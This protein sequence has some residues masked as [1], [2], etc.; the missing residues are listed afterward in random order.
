MSHP[1][2]KPLEDDLFSPQA[3]D[4]VLDRLAKATDVLDLLR[5]ADQVSP[6][7][8][9]LWSALILGS[10]EDGSARLYLHSSAPITPALALAVSESMHDELAS[11]CG[12]LP[13]LGG[14]RQAGMSCGDL[15]AEVINRF[16][17]AFHDQVTQRGS[18]PIGITRAGAS[19]ADG[20]TLQRWREA[21]SALEVAA[22]LVGTLTDEGLEDDAG[23]RDPITGQYSRAFFQHTLKNELA[24]HQRAASELSIVLLQLRR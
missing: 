1:M 13:E 21:D 20:L 15:S 3:A 22:W 11:C 6:P 5:Q 24:R 14:V 8:I 7:E 17:N 4:D 12:S 23:V 9:D 18:E 2:R 16:C 19:V 10:P